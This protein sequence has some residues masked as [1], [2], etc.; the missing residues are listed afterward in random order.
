[1]VDLNKLLTRRLLEL[2]LFLSNG[3]YLGGNIQPFTEVVLFLDLLVY[4]PTCPVS[5]A[6]PSGSEAVAAIFLHDTAR[7]LAYYVIAVV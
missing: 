6:T 5:R 3:A 1:M 2:I 4:Y 7:L